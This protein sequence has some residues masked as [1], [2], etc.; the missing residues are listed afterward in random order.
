MAINIKIKK[1]DNLISAIPDEL[2]HQP[3]KEKKSSESLKK[4]F[5]NHIQ[6][7]ES[8]IKYKIADLKS[9]ESFQK[10]FEKQIQD[11][12]DDIKSKIAVLEYLKFFLRE[13]DFINVF[14][15]IEEK[16]L[17]FE[18]LRRSIKK[19]PDSMHLILDKYK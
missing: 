9:S 1:L 12:Q 13:A 7:M 6:D 17:F 5:E 11:L 4:I 18:K 10:I 14:E 2:L 8:D 16:E 19:N 15:N 3:P